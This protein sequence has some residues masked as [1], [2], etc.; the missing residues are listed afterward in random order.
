MNVRVHGHKGLGL[1]ELVFVLS[2]EFLLLGEH[3]VVVLVALGT[4]GTHVDE[5]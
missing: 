1:V 3:E 5:S 2:F 4:N